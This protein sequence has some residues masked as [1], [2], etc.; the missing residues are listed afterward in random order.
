MLSCSFVE[1][2]RICARSSGVSDINA[3]PSISLSC[4]WEREREEERECVSVSVFVCVWE[5]VWMYVC[6]CVCVRSRLVIRRQ[7]HQFCPIYTIVRSVCVC[8]RERWR[9]RECLSVWVFVCV[10]QSVFVWVCLCVC[11]FVCVSER[12]HQASATSML[13][14]LYHCTVYVR[15]RERKRESVWA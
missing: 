6:V 12:G 3:A 1:V 14:H 15:E 4:V 9:E 2:M 11:L 8:E 13:P 10:W 7:R 5:T